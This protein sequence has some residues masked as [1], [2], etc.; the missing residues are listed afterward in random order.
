MKYLPF[1]GGAAIALGLWG[2]PVA[3]PPS[4]TV[5]ADSTYTLQGKISGLDSGWVY[6]YHPE[7]GPTDS[8]KMSHGQFRL[9]GK[10]I[11]PE[12][13]HLGFMKPDGT[14]LFSTPFF[15]QSGTLDVTGNK[16]SMNN[17]S[18][19]G[20]PLQ[21]EWLKAEKKLGTVTD[22]T[23]KKKWVKAYAASNPSSYV[24]LIEVR[25]YFSYN[26]DVAELQSIY[27]GLAPDLRSSP[28]GKL[29][30]HT[31]DADMLTGIGRPAPAF[32]QTDTEGKPVSLAS[33]QGQYVLIDFWASWCG[34]CRVENPN[35]VRS[36]QRYHAKGFT[37]L[38]VSLDNKRDQ[39]IAA[40]GKDNL[41]WTQVSDLK[42]WKN[43]VAVAYGVEGIPMNFLLDKDGTI[44]AKGLRGPEF[45]QTL[46]KLLH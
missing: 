6:L 11:E 12:Y 42:G 9:T 46:A 18:Y 39:W 8:M 2:R 3:H 38:G 19:S 1:I 40:I 37:V 29:L 16:N 34:P 32:T 28:E 27:N 45:E 17:L 20:A 26:P 31:L 23:A 5:S 33:F 25:I 14:H 44:I 13:C 24:A 30:K 21:E 7:D 22:E 35:V 36:Y 15:L 43:E 10:V 41:S 4:G